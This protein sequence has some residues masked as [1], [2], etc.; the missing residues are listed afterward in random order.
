MK[1]DD[2]AYY[3]GLCDYEIKSTSFKLKCP[4]DRRKSFSFWNDKQEDG[5]TCRNYCL[6]EEFKI[7]K[8]I[9]RMNDVPEEHREELRKLIKYQLLDFI[10]KV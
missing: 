4:F 6:I 8:G 3:Y 9:K 7:N 1:E 5:M 10:P 2:G